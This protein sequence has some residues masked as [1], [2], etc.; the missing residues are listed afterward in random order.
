MGGQCAGH[1]SRGLTHHLIATH[2]E[3]HLLNIVAAFH[4]VH[5]A[6]LVSVWPEL[7]K[8]LVNRVPLHEANIETVG[9]HHQRHPRGFTVGIHFR[10]LGRHDLPIQ[11]RAADVGRRG[12]RHGRQVEVLQHRFRRQ[13]AQHFQ[14][15][16]AS[17][18]DPGALRESNPD[19]LRR[20]GSTHE[21][22]T[23]H[24]IGTATAR[25][26][27]RLLKQP[28]GQGGSHESV[29]RHSA[30]GL[31]ADSD[32]V[33]IAAEGPDI[34]AHPLEGGDLVHDRVVGQR[35]ARLFRRQCRVREESEASQPIVE[36][37][38]NN[39][40]P[41]EGA[42]VVDRGRAAAVHEASP[43]NPHQHWKL[44]GRRVSGSP[45]IQIETIFRGLHAQWRG[46]TRKR[47]LHAVRTVGRR[48]TH[49]LPLGRGLR[50]PPPQLADRRQREWDAFEGAN[51]PVHA[52]LEFAGVDGDG[53][54]R[55]CRG[56]DDR[57]ASSQQTEQH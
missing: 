33:G 54:G 27:D 26:H 7:R 48:L 12:G 30:G 19:R 13:C 39:S 53:D 44:P 51:I 24:Q 42:A 43:V 57:R 18:L 1:V 36:A 46:V 25:L 31:A 38:E 6:R 5:G 10:G 21:R 17:R 28:G 50:R 40:I 56:R 45:D 9:A 20:I 2:A 16:R 35:A 22:T 49:S 8:Q 15:L 3:G 47:D 29:N 11:H 4:F 41:G 14:R 32:I 55:R 52:A 23:A 37:D 34:A